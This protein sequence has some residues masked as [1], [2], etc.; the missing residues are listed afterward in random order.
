MEAPRPRAHFTIHTHERAASKGAISHARL[1]L[2]AFGAG[3]KPE[4]GV[5]IYGV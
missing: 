3:G 1:V 2:R 4:R 5:Y